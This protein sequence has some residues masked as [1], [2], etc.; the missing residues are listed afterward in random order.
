MNSFWI[1]LQLIR[2]TIGRPKGIVLF[3]IL[4]SLLVSMMFAI[5]GR[6]SEENPNMVVAVADADAS[7]LGQRLT[8]ALEAKGAYEL[9]PV[10]S[11]AEARASVENSQADAAVIIPA[12]FGAAI[13]SG[14]DAQVEMVQKRVDEETFA[15]KLDLEQEMRGLSRSAAY[16]RSAGLEGT[17][18]Q[19]AIGRILDERDQQRVSVLKTDLHLY[20]TPTVAM[21]TGILILFMLILVSSSIAFVVEDRTN[22]TMARMY[23]A[24]VRAYEIALGNFAGS[25]AL[26]TLQTLFVLVMTR[27]AFGFDYGVGFWPHFA[28]IEFFLLAALG[29]GCAIAGIVRNPNHLTPVN[30]MIITPTCML[31][32]CFW[33]VELTPTF[34]QKLS[35]AVPQ[36]W[37]IDALQKLAAGE[38]WAGVS[39]NLAVLA[40]FAVVLLGFGSIV[41]KP[42]DA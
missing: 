32:G 35:Y 29:I 13:E 2:R 4:P 9:L 31:G 34:M 39:L 10:G 1:A 24:P 7:G 17:Q 3:L 27:Y 20:V 12:T 8:A 25:F 36:R 26:G 11:A 40:L 41:L 38:T 19:N 42:N 22:R 21:A 16:A 14:Q 15:L 23:T 6:D 30:S 28:V 18:L 33:P 5:M 37:A